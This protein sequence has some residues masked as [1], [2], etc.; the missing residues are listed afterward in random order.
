M[1]ANGGAIDKNRSDVL[2]YVETCVACHGPSS[3]LPVGEVHT[4][5]N[6]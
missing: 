3:I 2:G 5:L 1:E 6:E 4:A